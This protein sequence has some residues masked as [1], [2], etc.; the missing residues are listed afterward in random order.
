MRIRKKRIPQKKPIQTKN[1]YHPQKRTP[2]KYCGVRF[3]LDIFSTFFAKNIANWGMLWYN[4]V[5]HLFKDPLI[6]R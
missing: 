2:A 4:N 5:S 3:L 6:Y 1:K